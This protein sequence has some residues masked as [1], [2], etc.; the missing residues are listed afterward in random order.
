MFA[1]GNLSKLLPL[2]AGAWVL[3]AVV[4]FFVV[5]TQFRIGAGLAIG[6]ALV[7]NIIPAIL[8]IG[9]WFLVKFTDFENF[10]RQEL[11]V[12]HLS[13]GAVTLLI[14]F[15]TSYFIMGF[16]SDHE[17]EYMAWID[18]TLMMRVIAGFLMYVIMVSVFYLL[19]N[20]QNLAER[21]IHEEALQNLLYQSELNAL[22]AQIKPH[23]LFNALNSISSLTITNPPKA[24]EM[25]INLSDFMRY[26]LSFTGD[27]FSTFKQE[28]NHV[29]LYLEIE[30]VRFGD[31]LMVEENIDESLLDW[32][33]PPMILQPLM[34]N[35]VKHGMYDISEKS[36]IRMEAE[37]IGDRLQISISNSYDPAAASRKGTGTGL[38]N[39]MKRFTMIYGIRNLVQ[40]DKNEQI[41]KVQL[42]IPKNGKTQGT[43]Y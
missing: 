16:I 40:I 11:L 23:F 36:L 35:A 3:F 7:F 31:R 37:L 6:E 30:K 15:G 22:R 20:N 4:H 38:Q 17:G 18:Q 42:S 34:E 26:S 2:Y 1:R 41:F 14:W 29:K 13:M 5:F 33:L 25:V 43:D 28:L 12:R 8:G 9:L 10:S 39:V 21:K 24:Q 19:I 32:A 27:G